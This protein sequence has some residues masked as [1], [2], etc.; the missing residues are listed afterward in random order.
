MAIVFV[1]VSAFCIYRAMRNFMNKRPPMYVEKDP[2]VTEAQV[3]DWNRNTGYSMLFWAGF[4][5][6]MSALLLF[7]I[8]PIIIPLV[9]TAAGG[10]YFSLK[11]SAILRDKSDKYKPEGKHGRGVAV[12]KKKRKKK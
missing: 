2:D 12:R 5:L 7:N 3:K 4:S 10:A 11:A 1:F 6:T 8:W 9:L